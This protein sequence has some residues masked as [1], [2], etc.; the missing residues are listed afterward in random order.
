MFSLVNFMQDTN[1]LLLEVYLNQ[2][3]LQICFKT[4]K[5]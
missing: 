2:F 1:I 4:I 3:K 5:I